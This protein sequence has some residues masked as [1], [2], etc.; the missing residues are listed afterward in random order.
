LNF[1]GP[2]A[3]LAKEGRA[4]PRGRLDALGALPSP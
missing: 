1:G 2:T 4:L 3:A